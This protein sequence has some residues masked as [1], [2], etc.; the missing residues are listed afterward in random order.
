MR[1]ILL[2][3]H[4]WGP[5]IGT[6]LPGWMQEFFGPDRARWPGVFVDSG[7]Y[8]ARTM[9]VDLDLEGYIEW[10]TVNR[11]LIGQYANLDV[12]RDPEATARNQATMEAAGLAPVP[13][14]HTGSSWVEL[15][16]LAEQY[17]YV[18]LGGMASE[19]AARDSGEWMKW[20]VHAHQVAARYGC[21]LHGFG[22]T[23]WRTMSELP[24]ASV[25]SSSWTAGQRY[26]WV[27][28]WTGRRIV[29]VGIHKKNPWPLLRYAAEI[30]RLGFDPNLFIADDYHY[31]WTTGLCAVS[32]LHAETALERTRTGFRLY[33]ADITQSSFR[34]GWHAWWSLQD[35]GVVAIPRDFDTE[36][37]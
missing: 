18:A 34:Y 14:F 7:A 19:S 3:Y 26:G 1:N 22:V 29:Y 25:D 30:R 20:Q 11:S 24:W 2:S 12:I 31:R 37:T 33:L 9:G 8:T 13:V 36:E 27:S 15:H 32:W 4:Y 21:R 17:D 35:H 10:L 5:R 28:V 6:D 16:R 23:G